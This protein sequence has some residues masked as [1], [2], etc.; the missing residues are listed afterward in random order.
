ME[1]T[2]NLMPP[3]RSTEYHSRAVEQRSESGGGLL[4]PVLTL[5]GV[6]VGW[7]ASIIAVLIVL[8]HLVGTDPSVV[9]TGGLSPTVSLWASVA[10]LVVLGFAL[11]VRPKTVL[12]G[13]LVMGVLAAVGATYVFGWTGAVLFAEVLTFVVVCLAMVMSVAVAADERMVAALAL[14]RWLR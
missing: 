6:P 14:H 13:W 8:A 9:A 2:P 1:A 7:F 5:V 3:E 4:G 10:V 12:W 11:L